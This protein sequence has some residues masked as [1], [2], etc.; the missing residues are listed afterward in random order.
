[1]CCSSVLSVHAAQ[2]IEG[3]AILSFAQ[4]FSS[5]VGPHSANSSGT[6]FYVGSSQEGAQDFSLAA[7]TVFPPSFKPLMQETI[8][9]NNKSV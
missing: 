6:V 7:L 4:T 8:K 3:N 1:M 2:L 9:L 5:P